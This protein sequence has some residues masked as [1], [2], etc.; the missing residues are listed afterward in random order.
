M[1][2]I[3]LSLNFGLLNVR[4]EHS[5]RKTFLDSKSCLDNELFFDSGTFLDNEPFTDNK[6]LLKEAILTICL[7]EISRL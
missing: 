6:T 2:D 7:I 4:E 3:I 5:C 1:P